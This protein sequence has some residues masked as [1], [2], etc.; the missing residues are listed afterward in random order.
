MTQPNRIDKAFSWDAPM[1]AHGL[2]HMVITN[3][4]QRD[5]Y[6]IDAALHLHGQH[7]LELVDERARHY[8]SMLTATDGDRR[9]QVI[10][11]IIYSDAYYSEMVP[12]ADLI[13]PDTTY[14]ERWDCISLLDR[15]IS[16]ADM[17]ADSIRHP[18]VQPDRDVRGF[19]EV[20]IDLGARLGLPAF[21]NDDGSPKYPGGYPDYIVNHQRKPGLGPLAGW[22]GKDGSKTGQGEPNPEQLD[23]YLE[24]G[25]FFAHHLR[26]EQAYYKHANRA[27]LEW[28]VEVGF[29]V[30]PR[31]TIFQLYCEPL[32]VVPAGG[33]GPRVAPA[34]RARTRT[35][36]HVFRPPAVLVPAP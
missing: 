6:G 7:G 17:A 13:L 35:N 21:V 11:K 16:D 20:L 23:R 28:A 32:A 19:Q 5:P 15:P 27:Y 4:A 36:P 30:E 9:L 26:P 33:R 8:R 29:R 10:P 18:V 3:A 22:R 31:P 14:L 34:T 12:Y 2:M 24:N 25:A 1:S